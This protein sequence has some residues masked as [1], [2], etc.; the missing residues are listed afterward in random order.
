VVKIPAVN[1]GITRKP[2][3]EITPASFKIKKKNSHRGLYQ[4]TKIQIGGIIEINR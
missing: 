3:T 4:L 1:F 2:E